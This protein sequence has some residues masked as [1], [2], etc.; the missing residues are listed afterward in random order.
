M[1]PSL[2]T[3]RGRG[4]LLTFV[5]TLVLQGPMNNIQFNLQEVVRCITC[6]YQQI[7]DLAQNFETENIDLIDQVFR[8]FDDMSDMVNKSKKTLDSLL[9]TAN[10]D[11]ANKIRRAKEEIER[12]SRK[13]K[14]A[15]DRFNDILNKPASAICDTAGKVAGGIANFGIGLWNTVSG[16]FGNR[17]KAR[18]VKT[19]WWCKVKMINIPEINA[20][21]LDVSEKL[22]EVLKKVQG[23]TKVFDQDLNLDQIKDKLQSSS[24]KD[25]RDRLTSIFQTV[26]SLIKLIGRWWSKV[27]YLS[28]LFVIFDALLYQHKYY[29]DNDFD[30]KIIDGNIRKL[31]TVD[32]GEGFKKLTPLRNWERQDRYQNNI[33]WKLSERE[34]KDLALSTFP[35]L[36]VFMSTVGVV[37]VDLV[38]GEILRTFAENS[39]FGIYYPGM[40][41]KISFSSFLDDGDT[42]SNIL[43]IRA[44]DLRSDPCLPKYSPP[45]TNKN[46]YIF[47]LLLFCGLS[48][49]IDA[50]FSRFRAMI[51]NMFYPERAKERAKYLYK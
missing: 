34:R 27:F 36:I 23:D 31:W 8:S 5:I 32:Q 24:I 12:K 46:Y 9:T 48:C 39:K 11:Q 37:V 15:V 16:W 25:I 10:R 40:E 38:F 45:K 7:K 35:T 6:M 13:A 44:F 49:F 20:P 28:I 22:T 4:F 47:L 3:R 33:D 29:T 21:N 14:A 50:Y 43:R 42:S 30:N 51:C 17:N 2:L 41:Q 26:M 18:K 1:I 19:D